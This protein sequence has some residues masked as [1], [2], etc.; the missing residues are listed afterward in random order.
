MVNEEISIG[1]VLNIAVGKQN[2]GDL[3]GAEGIYRGI[4]AK[5]PDNA[6]ALHLIGLLAYQVGRYS[7]AIENIEKAIAVRPGVAV[8]LGNLGMAY[9]KLGKEEES[10]KCFMK[11]V[12]IDSRYNGAH[13]AYYNLGVYFK[14][15]G[16]MGKALENYD[17]AIEIKRDFYDARWNRSFILLLLGRYKE[18]WEDYESRFLKESSVD[19]R[20]FRGDKWKGEPLEGKRILIIAEQG[21]GDA[22]QFVRYLS[23][24]KEKGGYVILECKKELRRLFENGSLADEVIEKE[25]G[26]VDLEYDFYIHLMS[27]PRIFGTEVVFGRERYLKVDRRDVEKFM[28]KFKGDRFR[29]GICWAGNPEQEND[30]NRSM[31]FEKFEILKDISG[32]ELYS[33]QKGAGHSQFDDCCGI[34]DM[35]K[36]AEDFADTAAIIENL[37]LVISVDSSVAHLAGA[38]GKKVWTLLTFNPDWRW[39]VEGEDCLWYPTMRLFRQKRAGDWDTL[40]GEVREKL[41][42]V[43]K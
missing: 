25:K 5:Y 3:V 27:L 21:F 20:R 2:A 32:V 35:G 36:N 1:K 26:I 30:K 11:A 22:I 24:V 34:I 12:E 15:R 4:L 29:V 17:K 10:V 13:W 19:S 8:Y 41:E 6:D 31:S 7:E 9:D 16:E 39:G 37:D 28:E 43:L 33:L 40:M 42:K 23:L 38:M 14:D 18:G